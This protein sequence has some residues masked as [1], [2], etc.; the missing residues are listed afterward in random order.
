LSENRS[1]YRRKEK[2]QGDGTQ[3][4]HLQGLASGEES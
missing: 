2:D 1:D 4:L 3:S